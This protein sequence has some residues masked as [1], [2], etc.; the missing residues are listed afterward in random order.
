MKKR[1]QLFIKKLLGLLLVMLIIFSCESITTQAATGTALKLSSSR[2]PIKTYIISTSNISCYTS[3]SLSVRGTV[4]AGKSNTAYIAPSDDVYI[5]QADTKNF[6]WAKVTYPVGNK[7]YTAYIALSKLTS[8]NSSHKKTTASAKVMTY[9]RANSSTGAS[10]MYISKGESVYLVATSGSYYQVIYPCSGG[11][12]MAYVTKSNYDKY[13]GGHTNSCKTKSSSSV[14]SYSL[15]GNVITLKGKRLYEYPIGTKV[16]S[17]S[18]YFN[19]N[20]KSTYVGATQCYGFA[21]YCEQKLYGSCWHTNSSHFPNVNGSVNVKPN[22]STLKT[23]I[24]KA[25]AGAHLRSKNGHSMIIA[26]VTSSGFT[27]ID[28][29]ANRNCKVELRTYTWNSYLSSY[30][31]KSGIRFIEI[32]V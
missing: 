12:R 29:N 27:V 30:F 9:K 2:S 11:W 21:C 6:K 13:L 31:G 14:S 23:L 15:S 4:T 18:Y 1:K 16:P 25:G 3:S 22:A 19:V 10:S 17:S 24:T 5:V 8:N 28:A 20:G 26:D 7:R 32:H